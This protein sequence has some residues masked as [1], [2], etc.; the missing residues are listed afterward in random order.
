MSGTAREAM[1]SR[2]T[3]SSSLLPPDQETPGGLKHSD[4]WEEDPPRSVKEQ[5]LFDNTN[6]PISG[7]DSSAPDSESEQDPENPTTI[8]EKLL[9]KDEQL[10]DYVSDNCDEFVREN[11]VVDMRFFD[12]E[13]R[14]DAGSPRLFEPRKGTILGLC[15][16]LQDA[17][18]LTRNSADAS[19]AEEKNRRE[20]LDRRIQAD[21][22][23]YKKRAKQDH[24]AVKLC[25]KEDQN[26]RKEGIGAELLGQPMEQDST[27][28]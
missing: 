25:E 19:I 27:F 12:L 1:G 24:D 22:E 6:D 23:L 13:I 9:K 21:V 26:A 11:S 4:Q 5:Q 3:S 17:Y 18:N 10:E 14:A 8:Q 7:V 28:Q 15:E 2:G 16:A 20:D